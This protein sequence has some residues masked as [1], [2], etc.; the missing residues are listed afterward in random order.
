[1]VFLDVLNQEQE[2]PCPPLSIEEPVYVCE[3]TLC[4]AGCPLG[5]ACVPC[6]H[7]A[8]RNLYRNRRQRKDRKIGKTVNYD[9]SA[10]Q[11]NGIIALMILYYYI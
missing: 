3:T 9:Y 8:L 7:L 4:H 1:M 5:R 11:Y 10:D 2:Q 6:L